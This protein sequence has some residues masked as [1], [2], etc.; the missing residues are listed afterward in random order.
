[1]LGSLAELY[2]CR[3]GRCRRAGRRRAAPGWYLGGQGSGL[4]WI[5][6]LI[7]PI[8]PCVFSVAEP[9]H[10]LRINLWHQRFQAWHLLKKLAGGSR[11]QAVCD[12]LGL[13]LQAHSFNLRT[14]LALDGINARCCHPAQ[15]RPSASNCILTTLIPFKVQARRKLGRYAEFSAS[16]LDFGIGLRNNLLRL[17]RCFFPDFVVVE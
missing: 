11:F 15:F 10:L 2:L 7:I 6:L 4:L 3:Q 1:W 14:S 12:N 9:L 16:C 5:W 13:G 17:L 8:I